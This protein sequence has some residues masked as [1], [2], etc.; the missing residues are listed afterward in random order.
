MVIIVIIIIIIIIII[1]PSSSSHLRVPDDGVPEYLQ[2]HV[3]HLGLAVL[4]H[5]RPVLPKDKADR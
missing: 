1:I 5:I 4:G 2:A 3:I